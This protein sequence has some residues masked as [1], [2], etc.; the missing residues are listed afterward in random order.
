MQQ[1]HYATSLPSVDHFFTNL[2]PRSSTSPNRDTL[3]AS[4]EY[5]TTESHMIARDAMGAAMPTDITEDGDNRYII[6]HDP[7][8]PVSYS[9][10][11][12]GRFQ[13]QPVCTSKQDE[14]KN[15]D[16]ELVLDSGFRSESLKADDAVSITV[17]L[18]IVKQEDVKKEEIVIEHPHQKT[19]PEAPHPKLGM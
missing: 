19:D 17:D 10:P 14:E 8:D 16:L 4:S 12:E 11:S 5:N 7:A 3:G 9:Y 1:A 13:Q 15:I 18:D 2:L 6:K